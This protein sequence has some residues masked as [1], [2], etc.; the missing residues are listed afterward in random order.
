M[1][2]TF[3]ITTHQVILLLIIS[4]IA[5]EG[6][7]TETEKKYEKYLKRIENFPLQAGPNIENYKGPQYYNHNWF[8]GVK[9]FVSENK[10][11]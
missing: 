8:V 11:I 7:K 6:L 9:I 2:G 3:K 5:T 1:I 4:S 10:H